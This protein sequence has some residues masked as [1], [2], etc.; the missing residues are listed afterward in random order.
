[1]TSS[2]NSVLHE[3][4]GQHYSYRYYLSSEFWAAIAEESETDSCSESSIYS[5]LVS[6]DGCGIDSDS[7]GI[8]LLYSYSQNIYTQTFGNTNRIIKNH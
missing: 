6:S 3:N 8:Y 7:E 5:A 1:M 4:H 2:G